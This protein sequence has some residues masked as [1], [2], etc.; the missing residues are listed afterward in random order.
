MPLLRWGFWAGL[1]WWAAAGS[2]RELVT[3]SL[4]NQTNVIENIRRSIGAISYATR[5]P[6]PVWK[7]HFFASQVI[8]RRPSSMGPVVI[9]DVGCNKGYDTLRTVNLYSQN[10]SLT[11]NA[12]KRATGFPC[13]ICGQCKGHDLPTSNTSA[14]PVRVYCIEP[15]PNN[16]AVLNATA[17]R[18][19]LQDRGVHLHWGA[20]TSLE[21]ANRRKWTARFPISK[22]GLN[23][24]ESIG[25]EL[26]RGCKNCSMVDVPLMVMDRFVA[27]E[28]L[29]RVDILSIDTEGND[30]RVLYGAAKTLEHV[31]YVEF[32]YCEAGAWRNSTLEEVVGWLRGKGFVCYWIGAKR[33]WRITDCWH[34]KYETHRWSNVGCVRKSV[35][36]WYRLMEDI[37]Y[38]TVPVLRER[39]T[40]ARTSSSKSDVPQ[41]AAQAI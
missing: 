5:C 4:C 29:P 37:F 35:T 32:E 6:V 1:A 30:P 14:V 40:K 28:G 41:S 3:E 36:E 16:F 2:S 13:G 8:Q 20:M 18:L 24:I 19:Q 12:W 26:N 38:H 10:F 33:L 25:I 17:A 27:Q 21:D 15:V 31:Q 11:T 23:G 39:L 7:Q 9:F 34:L 22:K